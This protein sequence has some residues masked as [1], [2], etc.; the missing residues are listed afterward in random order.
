M[1]VNGFLKKASA[2]EADRPPPG[3]IS[4]DS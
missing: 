2:S 1:A 3:K 4:P